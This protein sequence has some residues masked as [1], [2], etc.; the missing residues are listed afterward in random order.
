MTA[1]SPS[2]MSLSTAATTEERAALQRWTSMVVPA[3][4]EQ[5]LP[6]AL[7]AIASSTRRAVPFDWEWVHTQSCASRLNV[8][9]LRRS[10][11]GRGFERSVHGPRPHIHD[12]TSM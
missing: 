6:Y 9:S 12:A 3:Y 7:S 4:A 10:D 8:F 5:S 11:Q 1:S 2:S